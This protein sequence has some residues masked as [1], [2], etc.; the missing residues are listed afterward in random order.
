MKVIGIS[1]IVSNQSPKRIGAF[2]QDFFSS[3]ISVLIPN[4]VSSDIFCLYTEYEGDYRAPY[5]MIIGHEVSSLDEIPQNMEGIEFKY[6]HHSCIRVIGEM[7]HAIL[8]VWQEIWANN[9]PRVYRLDF[10]R[11]KG[12]GSVDIFVEYKK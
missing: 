3:N 7:P 9:I 2:W 12:D 1:K 4:Q 6:D 8:K 11:H 10:Q 5:K